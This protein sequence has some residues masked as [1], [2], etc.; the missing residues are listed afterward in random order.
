M[1]PIPAATR[2]RCGEGARYFS[3]TSSP[4]RAGKDAEREA[5]LLR[6]KQKLKQITRADGSHRK[7]KSTGKS[8]CATGMPGWWRAEL[9]RLSHDVGLTPCN[10]AR[11]FLPVDLREQTASCER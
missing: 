11:L 3:K 7:E 1:P 10:S 9:L 8:A 4:A 6:K 2:F 5:R